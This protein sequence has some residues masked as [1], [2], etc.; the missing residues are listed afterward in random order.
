M[1]PARYNERAW[2]IDVISVIKGITV[3]SSRIIRNA[4]G[5][6]NIGDQSRSLF[7]DVLLFGDEEEAAVL[8]GWELKFPDTSLS[9]PEFKLNA[10]QKA[11]KL[12]LN[13]F[14]LWNVRE[15]ELFVQAERGEFKEHKRWLACRSVLVRE[16]V[17]KTRREWTGFIET[18]VEELNEFFERGVARGRKLIEAISSENIAEYIFEL[19]PSTAAFIRWQCARDADLEA[20][21]Y[22]WWRQAKLEYAGESEPYPS[23]A[24]IVLMVWMN[25]FLFA[26]LIKRTYKMAEAVEK[27]KGIDPKAALKIFRRITEQSDFRTIFFSTDFRAEVF[28]PEDAW[29]RLCEYNNFLSEF[30]FKTLDQ[31][32]LKDLLEKTVERSRRKA[33]GQFV[34]PKAVAQ[35][36]VR[37][38]MDDRTKN[39]IDPCCGSGTIARAAAELKEEAGI[40]RESI[41]DAVWASDKFSFPVQIASLALTTPQDIGR[42][43]HTFKQDA[44]DLSPRQKIRFQNPFDGKEIKVSLPRFHYLISNLPYLRAEGIPDAE[45]RISAIEKLVHKYDYGA[46]LSRRMD[47]YAYFPFRFMDLLAPDGKAGILISNS[48]LG[49]DW[50]DDF[51]SALAH[52]F[53]IELV[54]TAGKSRWFRNT[55]VVTNILILKRK[56]KVETKKKTA[57][58][59]VRSLL[60]ES[61]SLDRVKEICSLIRTRK[62]SDPNVSIREYTGD[63][64]KW[65]EDIGLTWAS[66]FAD[67]TWLPDVAPFLAP[68][69]EYLDVFRGERR[70]WNPMFYP[71]QDSGIENVYLRPA[72]RSSKSIERLVAIADSVAFCCG[73]AEEELK[74]SGH[75]GALK[76][77][78]KFRQGFNEKGRPLV[79]TLARA[80]YHWYE[81]KDEKRA[82]F[83]TSINPEKR[84]F[85]SRFKTPA[86]MDQRLFSLRLRNQR[87]DAE[88]IHALLNS[89]IC[90][91]YTE[92]LGFGRGLGALDLNA[93]KLK[94]R[95]R[96]LRPE[97]L[98]DTHIRKI[99]K[100]FIPLVSRDVLPLNL[101]LQNKQ[102]IAFDQIVLRAFGLER[103]QTAIYESLMHL[104]E[105][106]T[107]V[108][109]ES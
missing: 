4:G 104:F 36:L 85:Y 62:N 48:W 28:I 53:D 38:T 32:V 89:S 47:L 72:L 61:T 70:G 26:H 84:L 109:L 1:P 49:T 2:A 34:T 77:I 58:V 29:A 86:F 102:R 67:V 9:D 76:W 8:Q 91:F 46:R 45:K 81:M 103:L 105:V 25:R 18:L 21:I 27:I 56:A 74:R 97:N 99:K 54:V 12:G 33:L 7:P 22:L 106:R 43:I 66:F 11:R 65:F 107:S 52:F 78:G 13:S 16:D 24:K 5:E 35:M 68:V 40:P 17:Q 83:V 3:N 94:H 23:L 15:A 80:G 71:P 82:D 30:T 93:G 51:R 20:E 50:G 57:F 73:K 44:L 6:F 41:S 79:K 42:L 39:M 14:V 98:D 75:Q 55:D 101:E 90:L 60:N 108:R 59:T 100:S 63:E 69:R 96:I 87:L 37:L 10:E 31:A 19:A 92:A 95:M 64:I 88:L